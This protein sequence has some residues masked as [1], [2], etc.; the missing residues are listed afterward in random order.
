MLDCSYTA[1]TY[2]QHSQEHLIHASSQNEKARNDMVH[3]A[4]LTTVEAQDPTSVS[5]PRDAYE[6][7]MFFA[8]QQ[9]AYTAW[10]S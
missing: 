5:R 1:A 8:T 10:E 2:Q 9:H 4:P 6:A 3:L 7:S